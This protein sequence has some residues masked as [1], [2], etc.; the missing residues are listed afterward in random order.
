[1]PWYNSFMH[2]VR[3]AFPKHG[4]KQILRAEPE[5]NRNSSHVPILH[6]TDFYELKSVKDDIYN[7]DIN[8]IG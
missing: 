4:E 7:M 3:D 6:S 1:M 2:R 8:G 5:C